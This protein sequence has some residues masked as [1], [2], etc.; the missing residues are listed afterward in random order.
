M[1][2][3][4]RGFFGTS[5]LAFLP[6]AFVSVLVVPVVV[7]MA[8]WIASPVWHLALLQHA[9]CTGN[10]APGN[11]A[12]ERPAGDAQIPASFLPDPLP[13]SPRPPEDSHP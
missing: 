4:W 3:W 11:F 8:S 7:L 13:S 12:D 1:H 9:P 10:G 2:S 5:W 6:L